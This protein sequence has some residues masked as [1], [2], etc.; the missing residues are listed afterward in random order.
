MKLYA[1]IPARRAAQI[2]AD[3][4]ALLAIG[5]AVWLG[6]AVHGLVVALADLGRQL[7]EAGSGFRGTMTEIGDALG[8]VPLIGGG[9]RAPFDAASGAGSTLADAGRTQQEV[10]ETAAVLLG[11]GIAVT[12]IALVL[13]VWLLPR[14]RFARRAAEAT[15]MRA[16]PEGTEL[17]A[18]RALGRASARE[19]RAVGPAPLASWRQGDRQVQRRL[20][21][22]ELTRAGLR[23]G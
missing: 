8:G 19:L 21:Q 3:V 18:L 6:V 13:L 23:L 14:L 5:L 4:V 12:P 17:L 22:L 15:A 11:I 7:E 20:A 16:L 10:V 1:E 9:I 2:A